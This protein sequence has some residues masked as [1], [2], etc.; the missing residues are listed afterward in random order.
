[1][2]CVHECV[3]SLPASSY[4]CPIVMVLRATT[5]SLGGLAGPQLLP[6]PTLARPPKP[7]RLNPE[8]PLSV[9]TRQQR[10]GTETCAWPVNRSASGEHHL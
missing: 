2:A 7:V 5:A 8:P 1:M 3:P 6:A 9:T 4:D 10:I